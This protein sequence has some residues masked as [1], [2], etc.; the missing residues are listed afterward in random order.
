MVT[1]IKAY[2]RAIAFWIQVNPVSLFLF[3]LAF[4]M[5]IAF[6]IYPYMGDWMSNGC[7]ACTTGPLTFD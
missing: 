6:I 3:I 4:T 2:I 1:K 5:G 7:G